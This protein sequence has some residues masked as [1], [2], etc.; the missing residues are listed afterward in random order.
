MKTR[1]TAGLSPAPFATTPET[2]AEATVGALAGRAHTIWVPARLRL[3]FT[4]L[5]HLPRAI[6]RRLPL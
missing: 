3:I 4:A 6:Y 2:V 1:M 5:R